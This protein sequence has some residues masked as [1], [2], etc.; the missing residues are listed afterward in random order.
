[1]EDGLFGP[2]ISF[3]LAGD[4]SELLGDLA[5]RIPPLSDVDVAEM[6][7]SVRAAP[8]LMGYRGAPCLDVTAL[9]DLAARLSCLAEDLPEV[10]ELELNPVIVAENGLAVAGATSVLALP[11]PRA[12][13]PRRSLL[14]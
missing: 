9:E 11:A 4:A 5:H 3:G 7:H 1:M 8:R 13:G 14:T 10:A 2:V 12:D 6:I